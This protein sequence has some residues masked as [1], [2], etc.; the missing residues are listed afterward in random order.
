[1]LYKSYGLQINSKEAALHRFIEEFWLNCYESHYPGGYIRVFED[2]S[3]ANS[4]MLVVFIRVDSNRLTQGEIEIEIIVAGAANGLFSSLNWGSEG[5]RIKR[6][7]KELLAF[8]RDNAI[9][10]ELI[11]EGEHG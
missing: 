11:R 3:F 4:N 1:M 9:T 10:V 2:Y 7:E 8:C 5:R 6:F